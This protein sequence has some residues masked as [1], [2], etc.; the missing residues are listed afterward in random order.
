MR[1]AST[2]WAVTATAPSFE[3]FTVR[4]DTGVVASTF[5]ERSTTD[6]LHGLL[7][8]LLSRF[9][10]AKRPDVITNLLPRLVA[11]SSLTGEALLALSVD[12]AVATAR[13]GGAVASESLLVQVPHSAGLPLFPKIVDPS[14]NEVFTYK[15]TV[16]GDSTTGL[17]YVTVAVRGATQEA[18]DA[19][20]ITKHAAFSVPGTVGTFAVEVTGTTGLYLHS[21]TLFTYTQVETQAKALVVMD[22]PQGAVHAHEAVRPTATFI[23]ANGS[24]LA[25]PTVVLTDASGGVPE[26]NGVPHQLDPSVIY[27]RLRISAVGFAQAAANVVTDPAFNKAQSLVI[28]F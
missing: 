8:P 16:L 13:V 12:G 7:W 27:G 9:D 11:V 22:S 15:R 18:V 2:V 24:Q 19:I 26:T 3:L 23:S 14:P 10:M 25:T 20:S 6:Y 28:Q 4:L 1:V 5:F 21:V 17:Y